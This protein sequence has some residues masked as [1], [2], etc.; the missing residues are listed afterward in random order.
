MDFAAGDAA[1]RR[2]GSHTE[3]VLRRL[4]AA[5]IVPIVA[6]PERNP[7]LRQKAA[8]VE[9]WV[10]LGCLVQLTALSITGGFGGSARTAG[11][12]LIQRG[13]CTSWPA[14]LTTPRIAIRAFSKPASPSACDLVL[15]GKQAYCQARARWY[16][17]WKQSG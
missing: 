2:E 13:L 14:T 15:G 11:M 7:V 9:A 8:R 3:T 6:H 10:E 4:V 12:R 5:E 1:R 17:F 16:Q